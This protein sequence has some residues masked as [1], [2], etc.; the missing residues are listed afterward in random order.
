MTH[1]EREERLELLE[2]KLAFVEELVEQLN[3]V[4]SSQQQQIEHQQRQ[5]NRLSNQI[6]ESDGYQQP[7][8][9]EDEPPPPHY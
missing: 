7:S 2:C 4:V 8:R 5:L 9:V 3:S 1:S 6:K